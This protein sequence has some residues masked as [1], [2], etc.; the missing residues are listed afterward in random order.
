MTSEF[1]AEAIRDQFPILKTEI[2]GKKL[3][4]LDSAASAQKPQ[5]VLD[6]VHSAYSETYA[7]VHR[8]LHYLSEASTD[9]YEAVRGKVAKFIHA[10]D[11]KE[12]VFTSGA[13]MSLNLIAHSYGNMHLKAGDEVLISVAEHHANI[14]PWH[15]L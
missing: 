11:E 1:N 9:A 4:Y 2:H 14:V 5:M 8:G 13:T 10:T 6:A 7:N 12:V 15:L 3:V